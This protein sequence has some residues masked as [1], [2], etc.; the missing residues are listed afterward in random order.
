MVLIGQIT[1][2]PNPAGRDHRIDGVA[3]MEAPAP[4]SGVLAL[5]SA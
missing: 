1:Q 5:R 4:E 3:R 2:M